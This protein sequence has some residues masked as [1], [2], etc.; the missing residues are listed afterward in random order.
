MIFLPHKHKWFQWDNVGIIY[1]LHIV[2][3]V[4]QKMSIDTQIVLERTDSNKTG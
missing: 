1:L 4:D 3:K 2:L